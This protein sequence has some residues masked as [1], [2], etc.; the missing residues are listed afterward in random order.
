VLVE[1]LCANGARLLLVGRD[2]LALEAL[3]RRYPGQ[4]SLVCAD[5]TQRSGRHTVLDAARRF[6]GLNCVIN[7]AG[8]NQFSLLEQQDEDAIARLIGVNVTATLQLTHLLLPLLRQ[9]P[10]A[11]LVNLG[12]TFGS[13]GYPGFAAYCASKFALR[14]FSE[15]LRRELA[16]SHVKVLYIA[17]RATR[18]TMNSDDVVAMNNE[19]QVEMDDPQEVARQIVRAI[20]AEREELYLGWPEKL[21]VRLNGLLPRLVDQA[22]RKQLPV[23]KRFAGAEQPQ[24]PA[25]QPNSTGEHP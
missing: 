16:D 22:L 13:I 20:A 23:I 19:L 2:S 3:T 21:F 5:L 11:L 4:V 12:S 1:R 18:T 24:P 7:A 25:P 10:Q 17:P 15:A 9:Q 6:G 14:G 8:I